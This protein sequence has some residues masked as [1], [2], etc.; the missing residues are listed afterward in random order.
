MAGPYC[1]KLLAALGAEVIK[2]ESPPFGDPSRLTGPFLPNGD[3]PEKS[4]GHPPAWHWQAAAERQ[5]N[6]DEKTSW[7]G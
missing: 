7:S 6:E 4:R 1:G 3:H 5:R 2:V